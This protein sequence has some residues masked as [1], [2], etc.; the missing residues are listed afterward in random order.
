LEWEC[1][2][3]A[4]ISLKYVTFILI[5]QGSE[6]KSLPLVLEETLDLDLN[7]VGLVEILGKFKDGLNALCNMKWP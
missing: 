2:F 3:G 5:L 1:L 6:L 4:V 7:N